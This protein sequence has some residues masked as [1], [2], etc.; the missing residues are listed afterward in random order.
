MLKLFAT[1]PKGLELL[2]VEELRNL[3]AHDPKEKLAGVAF[4]GDINI[5][6]RACLWSRLANRILLHLS[7]FSATSPEELYAGIQTIVWDRHIRPTGTLSVKFICTQSNITHS[8]FGAQKVKDAIV[9]QLRAQ[10]GVRPDVATECP[11][12]SV[13]VLL[14]R[15]MASVS[16]DL[17]GESLHKRGYR[18]AQ[19][20]AP[21]KEN[22]AAAILLRSGWQEIAK[23]EGT[24][25]DPMC[26]SGT[27]LI[28][29]ALMACDIA[30]GLHR[31]YFGFLGW[32]QHNE[33]TWKELHNEAVSRLEEGRSRMPRIIGYDIDG[34]MIKIAHENIE[35]IGLED[36][37]HVEK[38]SLDD[39][40]LLARMQPGL[41]VVNPPYGERLGDED[42]LLL[43][44][45]ALG[46]KLK[47]E[48]SGWEA[49]MF[50]GN[51]ALGKKMGLRSYHRYKLFNG[52]IPCEL[53]LF[54]VQPEWF[55]DN[56]PE[57]ENERRIR[58][59]Q[60]FSQKPD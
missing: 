11:D 29:A 38:K 47:T 42:D 16:I 32:K 60:K 8:L 59:A 52:L 28:E 55:I 5:A 20:I 27:L 43:L 44:Y 14:R 23:K 40:K 25:L 50:T 21:L 4:S 19:G 37:I 49:G 22:L 51:P 6:Y 2:L 18:L 41:V 17:S 53:L 56:S 57:A 34:D 3:G 9:D 7:D 31:D 30:P 12:V 15:D 36:K 58:R 26:G 10:Y 13:H 24:L 33:N 35:R 39:C 1:C 54:H 46:D 48:F 45:R